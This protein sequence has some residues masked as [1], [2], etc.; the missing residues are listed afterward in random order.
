[1]AAVARECETVSDTPAGAG[2]SH[3]RFRVVGF[4]RAAG[5]FALR[6]SF[7]V[8]G[9]P[10]GAGT[11][12]PGTTFNFTNAPFSALLEVQGRSGAVKCRP[13]TNAANRSR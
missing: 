2:P 8:A 1:M 4:T 13:T 11:H 12:L 6:P 9:A 5:V 7:W 10:N 3:H